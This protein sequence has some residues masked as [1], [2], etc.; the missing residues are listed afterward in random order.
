MEDKTM[1]EKY[2]V[3]QITKEKNS[4]VYATAI[5]VKDS[6]KEARSLYHQILASVYANDNIEHAIVQMV[7]FL[8][9][10]VVMDVVVPEEEPEP[11]EE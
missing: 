9:Y 1:N 2:F 4:E 5:T 7:N 10:A 8:G 11:E 3:T 6:E